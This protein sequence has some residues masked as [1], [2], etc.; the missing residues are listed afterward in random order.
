MGNAAI[1]RNHHYVPQFALRHFSLPHKNRIAV[2]DKMENKVFVS[3][4]RNVACEKDYYRI[5][6]DDVFPSFESRLANFE[7]ISSKVIDKISTC[8]NINELNYEDRIVLSL[9]IAVQFNRGPKVRAAWLALHEKMKEKMEFFGKGKKIEKIERPR[10]IELNDTIHELIMFSTQLTPTILGK[11]WGIISSDHA[12]FYTSDSPVVLMNDILK[13]GAY[14]NLGFSVPWIKIYFPICR[15][16]VLAMYCKN[17]CNTI[18]NGAQTTYSETLLACF[19]GGEV[20]NAN[21]ALINNINTLQVESST[22]YVFSST[23]GFDLIKRLSERGR[24]VY[25]PPMFTFD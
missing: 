16:R 12:A 19:R 14:G 8:K 13:S 11:D 25:N 22:R 24:V 10:G 3:S 5:S 2:Y 7:D 1:A 23:P 18:A 6:M 9:Y 17:I 15:R 21:E 20:M 4:V